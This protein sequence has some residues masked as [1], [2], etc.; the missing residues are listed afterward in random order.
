MSA[1]TNR[2][3][4]DAEEP[5][6]STVA[7]EI[8]WAKA[9]RLPADASLRERLQA[10]AHR[11]RV[12]EAQAVPVGEVL[13]GSS[14]GWKRATKRVVWRLTRFSTMRYDRSLAELAELVG[15]LEQRLE[16]AE[17]ELRRIRGDVVH[18]GGAPS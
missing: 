12:D 18:D 2:T 7:R 6:A 10:F 11:M 17:Q 13:L 15:L 3:T 5:A 1:P 16:E 4:P 14:T 9:G 8:Y